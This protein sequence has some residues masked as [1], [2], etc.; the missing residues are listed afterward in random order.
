MLTWLSFIRANSSQIS[1]MAASSDMAQ[2][3]ALQE[4]WRQV[5]VVRGA[6][7]IVRRVLVENFILFFGWMDGGG[8]WV[9]DEV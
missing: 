6:R 2:A 1:L 9:V 5:R 4:S 8:V 7:R 3:L